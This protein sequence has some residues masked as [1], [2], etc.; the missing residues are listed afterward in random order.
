MLK[1]LASDATGSAWFVIFDQEA[2]R[3]I[4]HKLSFVL[5]E[6]NKVNL[7]L[8]F[9]KFL[10]IVDNPTLILAVEYSNKKKSIMHFIFRK[11]LA[12]KSCHQ[13]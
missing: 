6:F 4:E 2:E 10:I 5:E 8:I 9:E 12:V 1:V 13:L 11:D 3:I 7:Y